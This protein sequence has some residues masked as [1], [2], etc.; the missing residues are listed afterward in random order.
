MNAK[1]V[2]IVTGAARGIGQAIAGAF[3]D[4]G[5]TVVLVDRDPDALHSTASA[6]EQGGADVMARIVDVTRS[7][8]I[9]RLM[10]DVIEERGR[11]DVLVNNAGK[12][13]YFDA[14]TMTED[15]WDSAMDV[16]LK[17]VWLMARAA[18]PSLIESRGSIVNVSSIHARLTTPGMF[19]YAA[20]KSGVEGLTR[21]LAADYASAG[22]R[23]N[24]VAP[25]WTQ[26]RLVDE[27]AAR[28]D[29]PDA[30]SKVLR[31]HPLQRIATPEDVAAAVEFL[32]SPGARAITGAVLP[33]D[34]G[35][36]ITFRVD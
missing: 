31:A 35:L 24:A 25:G 29:D 20:A 16:D 14:V 11:I 6:L 1:R 3:G 10:S 33:V 23:V 9:D 18:L 19:P 2:V 30:L 17:S 21:S 27:W 15:D 32:A 36:S 8:D 34:C 12:N 22:V 28:S 7:T 4:S 5:D 26:T 13:T